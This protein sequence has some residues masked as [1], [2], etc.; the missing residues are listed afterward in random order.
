MLSENLSKDFFLSEVTLEDEITRSDGKL[1]VT[2]KGTLRLLEEWLDK[3]F[4]AEDPPQIAKAISILKTIRKQRQ[5]P[6]HSVSTDTFDQT[7]VRAQ[8]SLMLDAL[9]AVSTLRMAFGCHPTC[10]DL[11]VNAFIRD[12]KVWTY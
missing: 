8:R 3:F 11:D 10:R 4:H 6:A 9:E 5:S 7:F 1:V 12:H 2:Q